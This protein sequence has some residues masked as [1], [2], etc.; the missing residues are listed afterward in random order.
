ML[1][2]KEMRDWWGRQAAS[3][4]EWR[5]ESAWEVRWVSFG[6]FATCT[7]ARWRFKGEGLELDEREKIELVKDLGEELALRNIEDW[8]RW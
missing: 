7:T 5:L 2:L 6:S 8:C 4:G 1:G 3:K